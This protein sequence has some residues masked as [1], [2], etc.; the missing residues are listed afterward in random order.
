MTCFAFSFLNQSLSL[1]KKKKQISRKNFTL[2]FSSEKIFD[3]K[4]VFSDKK[5]AFSD[6]EKKKIIFIY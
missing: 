1:K 2:A 6:K 3:K 5:I 4:I